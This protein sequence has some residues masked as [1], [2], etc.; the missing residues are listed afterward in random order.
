MSIRVLI[1]D[2]DPL[3]RH[4][5]TSYLEPQEDLALVGAV[6]TAEEAL[7]QIDEQS[8]DLVLMDIALPG[9]DGIEATRRIRSQHPAVPV[10]VL[11]TFGTDDQVTAALAAGAGGF[12]LKSTSASA[13]VAAVRAVASGAGTLMTPQI[14]ATL[15][16]GAEQSSPGSP[17]L[18]PRSVRTEDPR[19]VTA[20]PLTG[21]ER[22]VLELVCAAQSNARIA[23]R[24]VLSESTVKKHI[25]SLMTKL[26][27][28]SRLQIALRAFE[29]G[30]FEPPST[31]RL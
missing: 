14:A 25:G 16:A 8:P 2:D 18:Q 15:A 24:L 19:P 10:L 30:I 4:A 5:L 21:R 29:L 1:C 3:V 22:D 11:T 9:I 23:R 12:L 20:P 28:T 17:R 27:A 6:G 7:A 13:L 26:D 31:R